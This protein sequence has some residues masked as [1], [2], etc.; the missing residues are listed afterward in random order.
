M[1]S[2]GR[3]PTGLRSGKLRNTKDAAQF[4]ESMFQYLTKTESTMGN[5]LEAN[6]WTERLLSRHAK[7]ASR[8]VTANINQPHVL[9]KSRNFQP[10]SI[11]SSFRVW[12]DYRSAR[13]NGSFFALTWVW[14]AY[15]DIMSIL[16]QHQIV[17]P[18][19]KSR[20]HLRAELQKAQSAYEAILMREMSFPQA[21]QA[22]TEID[23]WVDQVMANWRAMLGPFW[24][25]EDLGQGGNAML[26]KIILDVCRPLPHMPLFHPH[27]AVVAD[28]GYVDTLPSGYQK[29]PFNENPPASVHGARSAG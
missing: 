29:L 23:S 16:V 2:Q 14:K 25:D 11:L 8:H 6:V 27:A 19:F 4:Y 9:L 17:H 13:Q 5:T 21:N 15:Y 18:I 28:V 22:N 24:E 12:S 7:L 3:I 10:T 26:G 20:A 1:R